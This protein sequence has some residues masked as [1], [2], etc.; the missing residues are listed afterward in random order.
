MKEA[1]LKIIR[2]VALFMGVLVFI[3]SVAILTVQF[4]LPRKAVVT[5]SIAILLSLAYVSSKGKE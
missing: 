3:V 2:W 5:V 4:N 1:L